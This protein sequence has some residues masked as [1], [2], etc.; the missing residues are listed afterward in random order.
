MCRSL[1]L[2]FSSLCDQL[3]STLFRLDPYEAQVK[4]RNRMTLSRTKKK[5]GTGGGRERGGGTHKCYSAPPLQLRHQHAHI[6]WPMS[7]VTS[8]PCLVN[9]SSTAAFSNLPTDITR[10]QEANRGAARSTVSPIRPR[11][12]YS[13][14][15]P[16]II[17]ALHVARLERV[18][19]ASHAYLDSRHACRE[20]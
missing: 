13:R 6:L 15:P 11:A 17:T 2:F 16:L 9:C 10:H 8:S 20:P 4:R 18:L 19:D 12:R 14:D 5:N 1:S 3:T 7:A